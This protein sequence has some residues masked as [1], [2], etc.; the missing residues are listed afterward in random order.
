[1]SGRLRGVIAVLTGALLV[2][3]AQPVDAVAVEGG[4]TAV[5]APTQQLTDSVRPVPVRGDFDGDGRQDIFWYV[6]GSGTDRLWS[7]KARTATLDADRFVV[8]TLNIS[9]SYAPA[10]GDFDA[11]GRDDIFWYGKGTLPDSVWY[12]TGRGTVASKPVTL[13]GDYKL[14]VGNFNK[15]GT[16]ASADDIFLYGPGYSSMWSGTTSRTFTNTSYSSPPPSGAQVYVGNWRQSPMTAGAAVHEDLLFYRPGTNSDVIWVGNGTSTF[17]TSPVTI[18][19][20]YAPIVGTFDDTTTAPDTTDIFWYAPGTAKDYVW[21]NTGSGFTSTPQTVNGKNYKPVV[22]AAADGGQSDILWNDPT[23]T[24]FIWKMTGI[25]GAFSHQSRTLSQMNGT[26]TDPGTRTPLLTDVTT[27]APTAGGNSTGM[28]GTGHNHTCAVT[29]AGAAECWGD[30][31]YNQIGNWAVALSSEVPIPVTGLTSGVTAIAVGGSHSCALMTTGTVKCWGRGSD[32]QLGH[33][34]SPSSV[35]AP[36]DVSGL[37]DVTAISAG[38][39]HSCAITS[40]GAARCWGDNFYGQLGNGNTG[41]DSNVPV[42]VTDRTSGTATISAGA[43]YSCAVTS[44][45][46]A[47]CW[48]LNDS[49]QLGNANTGTNSNVPVNVSGRSTGTATIDTGVT[50]TCAVT[51]TGAAQCWGRNNRG[52]LGNA[53]TGTNSNVPVNVSGRSTGTASIDVGWWTACATTTAGATQ[54]WGDNSYGQLGDNTGTNSN[55][56]VDVVGFSDGTSA[57]STNGSHSCAI[58]SSGVASCWG[59]SGSGQLGAGTRTF[60]WLPLTV[61]GSFGNVATPGIPGNVDLLWWAPG[62]GAGQSEIL[63]AELESIS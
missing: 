43:Y 5:V 48:G 6:A 18:N 40:T 54:C 53:N 26:A 38:D 12:F 59:F 47:Q 50:S 56:P 24:D 15:A 17:T 33:G 16:S 44:S 13:G 61:Q 31:G 21:M 9:G 49:G 42:N 8:Q 60:S 35:S 25:D 41:T 23:G 36:V 1:M 4:S 22:L 2:A 14:H 19:G 29:S 3:G 32:G 63:W 27:T 57:V 39:N 51:T 52:Q 62:N 34:S 55:V 37:T 45:G 7:G 30:D 58:A 11:D 28:I 46:A 20:T 10:V